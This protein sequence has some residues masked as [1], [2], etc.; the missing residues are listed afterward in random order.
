[1][2]RSAW[3][4]VKAGTN[5]YGEEEKMRARIIADIAVVAT[6]SGLFLLW[7]KNVPFIKTAE[8]WAIA[9]GIITILVMLAVAAV[10]AVLTICWIHRGK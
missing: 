1:M 8:G 4:I 2:Q 9:V 5:D 10:V 7:G 3:K 6:M